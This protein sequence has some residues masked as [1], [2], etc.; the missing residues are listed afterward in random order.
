M[1]TLTLV[2][3]STPQTLAGPKTLTAPVIDSAAA[4]STVAAAP[5][6]ALGIANKG[7]VDGL[8]S[9]PLIN[10][11]LGA[12]VASNILTLSLL[13]AGGS[14]PSAGDPVRVTFRNT[15]DADGSLVTRTVS[16]ATT[17][18]VANGST[19][20]MNNGETRRLWVGLIDNAGTVEVCVWNPL[21]TDTTPSTAPA[22]LSLNGFH[23]GVDVTTTAEA[24]NADNAH[25]LYS[26]NAR[27]A[28]P[29]V[30]L[31]FIEITEATAGVWATAP[32]VVQTFREGY[33][34]TGDII[35]HCWNIDGELASGTTQIPID[36]TIPQITE[37][38]QYM[39]QAITPTSA[40][41]L[42]HIN[43]DGNYANNQTNVQIV[44][45]L[46][47]DSTANARAATIVSKESLANSPTS[48]GLRYVMLSG[49]VSTTT[50]RIRAGF[51]A[52]GTTR[53][54]SQGGANRLFGSVAASVLGVQEV[55]V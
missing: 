55:M 15:T 23:P 35:Q 38:D 36:D 19:L 28:V 51:A 39:T 8:T 16:A 32:A 45:A 14:T 50:F 17:M 44:V 24:S 46:F 10:A 6:A 13:T 22:T 43:H 42:L 2:D 41:N 33:R 1:P 26:T 34:K 21:L 31:G 9:Q 5:T 29:F 48:G 53:F 54:N 4:G 27:T 11:S 20:G 52:A 40:I 12:S 3:T 37:G 25:V 30:L 47:Q 18:T 7:Y 49:T